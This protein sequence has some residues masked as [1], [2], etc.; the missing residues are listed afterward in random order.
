VPSDLNLVVDVT[1]QHKKHRINT[2]LFGSYNLENVKAAIATGLFMDVGM[3]D[4]GDA[5]SKYQ[6]TN[7]RSQVKV[8]KNNTL[9]CDYYNANP[10]SMKLSIESFAALQAEK[11]VCILGDMLEMGEKALEEHTN[12]IETLKRHKLAEVYLA[13]PVFSK[14]AKSSGF[15]AF[16]DLKGLSDYLKSHP[17]KGSHILLKGSRGMTMEKVTDLL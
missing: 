14:A 9:I 6:P 12:I 13:G 15:K 17:V 2:S 1:Y 11:K 16:P 8:T 5:I 7:N 4:I 3:E 10:L